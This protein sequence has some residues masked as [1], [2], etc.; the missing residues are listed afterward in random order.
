M[1]E[2]T[3][4]NKTT[5]EVELEEGG[6]NVDLATRT[7][8]GATSRRLPAAPVN[9]LAKSLESR[10]LQAYLALV[11]TD[12]AIILGSFY[13]VAAIYFTTLT[14]FALLEAGLLSAFLI[15]PL[16]LT[17]G[18][19]NGTY[20]LRSLTDWQDGTFKAIAALVI[21]GALL[22]FLAFFAKSNAEFSRVVFTVG[23]L[24]SMALILASRVVAA[25]LIL[26]W[27]GPSGVNKLVIM[28][29]GPE[30]TLPHA[31][32]LDAMEHGLRPDIDDPAALDRL[33]KYMR[34]MD[35]VIVSCPVS[36]GHQWAEVLKGTGLHGEVVH[37]HTRDIR[38]LGVVHHDTAGV[39]A[40]LVSAG[41]LGMR[42]RT[43]KR[44]FDLALTIP[45]V[46]LLAFPLIVIAVLIKLE[47]GGPIF[48]RQRRMGRGNQ[49]FN[50]LKFR[51]MR[52]ADADG[53]RSAS[54]DDAR[55]T[56]IGRILRR[57]SIDELPQLLNVLN[58]D[59]SL[60]GPRPHALGSK[61]G[62]K[63]FWE[64]DRRYWQRHGLRPGITGLAQIRG[65]R[66]ATETESD[67]VDRLNAD[68]EYTRGWSLWRDIGIILLTFRVIVHDRA[69]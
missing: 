14:K 52:V 46:I 11:V 2:A 55:V 18:L 20:S 51:S 3:D 32:Q 60:V 42:A 25:R 48:F 38:A 33:S 63:P 15:L 13:A 66:G 57:T 45:A 23:T 50:I 22:N 58:G 16:Y 64:V 30:F 31:F 17:I 47:D 27:W 8:A 24:G 56:R 54:R 12:V 44:A 5:V 9:G 39:S 37:E 36:Q 26:R 1:V 49:F 34:N 19:Y 29:G 21:S 61:A 59:M 43:A 4:L 10:R 68:L 35:Q 65:H 7:E 41:E 62:S 69:Y 6:T 67:L 28:A 40:L 53:N